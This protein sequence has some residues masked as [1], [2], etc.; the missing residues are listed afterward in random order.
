[1]NYVNALGLIGDGKALTLHSDGTGTFREFIEEIYADSAEEAKE[2]GA[3]ITANWITFNGDEATADLSGYAAS[4]GSRQKTVPAF[5]KFDLSSA[6]NNEFGDKHFTSYGLAHSTANGTMADSA[7]I[8]AMNPMNY[9]GSA[10]TAKYWRIYHGTN[11]RDT[12]MAIPAILAVK[13]ENSGCDVEFE[14]KWG[15]GHGGNYDLDDVFDW[16]DDICR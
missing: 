2:D 9:I 16:I 8:K 4:F 7:V 5:D 15:Q 12:S 10:K 13:L 11:D 1:M 6:E 3:T 14:A